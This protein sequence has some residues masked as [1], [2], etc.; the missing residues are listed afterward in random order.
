MLFR[1][2]GLSSAV[3]S[4]ADSTGVDKGEL[5]SIVEDL[6]TGLETGDSAKVG[7]AISDLISL[8]SGNKGSGEAAP[9]GG[10]AGG[11]ESPASNSGGAAPSDSEGGNDILSLLEKLLEKLGLSKEQISKIMNQL[12]EAGVGGG[13]TTGEGAMGD[14][15]GG[16]KA[17]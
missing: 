5:G 14:S 15:V 1:S 9:G 12:Q 10:E 2:S 16:V 3:S 4:L 13:E 7:Q 8:L 17:A 11:A 6:K